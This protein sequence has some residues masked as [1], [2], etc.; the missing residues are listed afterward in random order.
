MYPKVEP[1]KYLTSKKVLIVEADRL[2]R[3]VL[4]KILTNY[5]S[6]EVNMASSITEAESFVR[7]VGY[8]M[9]IIGISGDTTG[10]LG[11]INRLRE[12]NKQIPIVVVSGDCHQEDLEMTRNSGID[13]IVYKPLKLTPFLETV[14]G[15][16]IESE[17]IVNYA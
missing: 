3:S 8:D 10:E 15:A 6:C 16:F 4:S 11:L 17:R 13:R 7:S 14:A 9:Y 2:T 1:V 5:L 12:N